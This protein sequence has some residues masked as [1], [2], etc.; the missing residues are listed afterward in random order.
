VGNR[1]ASGGQAAKSDLRPVPTEPEVVLSVRNLRTY[2]FTARGVGK[3][4][5]GVSFDLRRGETLGLVGESGCGK[6]ITAL[7]IMGLHPRP[8]SRIIDGEVIFRGADLTRQSA[9]SMRNFRG[10]HL[11]MILQDPMTALDPLF[12]I[13]SQVSEGM[14]VHLHLRATAIRERVIELLRLL[15]ITAPE[16]RL[17][18]FP[19]QMSGGM[20][21]RVVGAIGISCEPEILIAD[22]PTTSLD[23][24][25]QAAYLAL[26][27][28]I[29]RRSKLSILFITHDFGIVA[30]MC[31]RVA[32]MYAGK[33]IEKAD[34][35]QLFRRPLHPYTEALLKSVPNLGAQAVRL[36]SIKGQPPSVYNLGPGCPFA[37]RCPYAMPR[38]TEEFPPEVEVEGGHQTSCWRYVA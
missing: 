28:D 12:T 26:L 14:R 16:E 1:A 36:A 19:H 4:V 21:Q 15:R 32:V 9:R 18:S 30:K 25:V 22:E 11:G 33:I 34:T 35:N 38:C 17:G 13:Q 27:R 8:A 6:S 3:A 31:D 5:D 24:T 20:R 37:P 7:S 2:F 23:V 10:R 29:Q